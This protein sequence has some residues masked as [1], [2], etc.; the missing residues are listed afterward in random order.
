MP[1]LTGN[2]NFIEIDEEGFETGL[3][4]TYLTID[5]S[6][7]QWVLVNAIKDQ[8]EIIEEQINELKSYKDTLEELNRE[9]TKMEEQM[10]ELTKSIKK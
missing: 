10:Q 3:Q 5:D 1:S 9:M 4:E 6:G 8:Q 7:F 2:Y